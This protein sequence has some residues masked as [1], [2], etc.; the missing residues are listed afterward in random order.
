MEFSLE[1]LPSILK[2]S[3]GSPITKLNNNTIWPSGWGQRTAV[4][5]IINITPDSFSDGGKYLIEEEALKRALMSI[6]DGADVIDLGAQSTRP[7]ANIIS[8]DEELKRLLPILKSIR[9]KL[10]NSIISVDTFHSSVAEKALEE[11]ADWINDVTGSKYDKRMVDVLSS[12]NFPYVL[13]HSKSN[14]KTIHS[15]A[16]YNNVVEDVYQSL[17]EL[18]D[19]AISKG[20]REKNIIWDPGIGFSKNREH[21][22]QILTNIDK[23]SGGNFPLIIGASRKRFIGEIINEKNPLKRNAGNISVVCKCVASNVDMVRVHDV[24]ETI[25]T[26]RLANELWK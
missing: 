25:Q 22:I 26:I 9:S 7:G 10:P 6:K 21:N 11:G 16:E 8:P 24:K 5:A 18:T 4:M 19:N 20:I 12:G 13:T 17:I 3:Q 2:V 23:F 1:E 14:N 15:Q